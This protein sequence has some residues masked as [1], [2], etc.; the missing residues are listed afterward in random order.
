M[1]LRLITALETQPLRRQELYAQDE[2]EDVSYPGDTDARAIHI[3]AFVGASLV[4]VVS[5]LPQDLPSRTGG[6][7]IRGLVVLAAVNRRGLGRSLIEFGIPLV[8]EAGA[9]YIWCNAREN[10]IPF[11]ERLG[12]TSISDLFDVEATGLHRRMV[13]KF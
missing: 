13:R 10:S 4:A 3:G 5:F 11:F 6:F 9:T 12:F 8:K 7:R 2:R 1:E